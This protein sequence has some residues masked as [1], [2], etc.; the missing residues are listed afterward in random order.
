M[1]GANYYK[2]IKMD[3][4]AFILFLIKYKNMELNI[5]SKSFGISKNTIIKEIERRKRTNN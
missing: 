1:E 2:D 4:I 5:L 3:K